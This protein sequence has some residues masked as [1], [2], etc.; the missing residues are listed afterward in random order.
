[1]EHS[2]EVRKQLNVGVITVSDT[3]DYDTDK[4]GKAIIEHLKDIKI[5]VSR[6]H[7][8]IA[9]DDQ[10]DIRASILNL[11]HDKVDVIITTGGTGVAKR[12][13]TIEVVTS[14][15]DKEM[16]GFGE[17]FRYLSYT[18]DV[19]TRAMLSRALCGTKDNTVIF[20][21]P[22][23]VGAVNLAMKKLITQEIHHIV[24]ELN[25]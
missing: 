5:D 14:I 3:R 7:Y 1:M 25:K 24:H 17:I 22:G 19:G 10:A 4:G 18:E 11:L 12:D 20:S 21:I 2:N 9:K 8:L 13:V 16:E 23:S 15:I 6:E